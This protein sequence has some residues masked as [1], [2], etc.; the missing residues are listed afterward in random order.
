MDKLNSHQVVLVSILV[1]FV[2]SITTGIITFSLLNESPTT[3]T[4]TINKVVERTIERVVSG[5]STAS[6]TREVTEVKVLVDEEDEIIS[7]I[8]SARNALVSLYNSKADGSKGAYIGSGVLLTDNGVVFVD[9]ELV[10]D[11]ATYIGFLNNG[12]SVLLKVVNRDS[13]FGTAYLLPVDTKVEIKNKP[14]TLSAVNVKLGQTLI[15][16]GGGEKTTIAKGIATGVTLIGDVSY[17]AVD[18]QI[19]E[20]FRHSLLINT[21]GEVV[22]VMSASARWN[23]D[24]FYLSSAKIKDDVEALVTDKDSTVAI[25][26]EDDG[27]I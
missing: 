17:V 12:E 21:K 3:V 2:T 8:S 18:F 7:A 5:E 11:T 24:S 4:Q 14:A 22:G 26:L 20:S 9:R 15:A 6:V 10:S 23:G 1:S 16:I 13:T 19:S 25:S 27:D